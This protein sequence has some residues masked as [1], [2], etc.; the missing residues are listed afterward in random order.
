MSSNTSSSHMELITVQ[1]HNT[2]QYSEVQQVYVE[3]AT[4]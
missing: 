2:V 3:N 4:K 1:L